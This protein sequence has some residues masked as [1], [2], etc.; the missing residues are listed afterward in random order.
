LWTKS[1][2][3]GEGLDAAHGAFDACADTWAEYA[4]SSPQF[5]FCY[6]YTLFK[7]VGDMKGK[8]VLDMPCG[9]GEQTERC[10][11]NGAAGVTSA[12]ISPEQLKLC[13]GRVGRS[14]GMLDHWQGIE[15]DATRPIPE[16]QAGK[17]DILLA[18][19]LFEYCAVASE[20]D[21]M[22]ANLFAAAKPGARLAVLY[23]ECVNDP[24]SIEHA[25]ATV[26]AECTARSPS[27]KPGDRVR[28]TWH[29]TPGKL[30]MEVYHWPLEHA[31][32]ALQKA[33][34]AELQVSCLE[35]D[36]AYKGEVDLVRFATH[37]ENRMIS[38]I[39]PGHSESSSSSTRA[40]SACGSELES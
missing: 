26:G 12:D 33:G 2:A 13:K 21:A 28:I 22:A 25:V 7:A 14:A 36:P 27:I 3:G 23:F 35:V 10:L 6:A 20:L 1:G 15:G 18:F 17:H 38:C 39:H 31:V 11:M 9:S 32:A 5:E 8:L 30:S 16:L 4:E 19:F 24:E 29:N 34:F 37:T 40:S